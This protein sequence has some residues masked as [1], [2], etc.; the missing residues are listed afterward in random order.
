MNILVSIF[1]L[2]AYLHSSFFYKRKVAS[3]LG[4][5]LKEIN[6]IYKEVS[7]S[8]W[9][10]EIAQKKNIKQGLFDFSMLSPLRAQTL[11]VLCRIAK[12]EIVVETGVSEGFSSTF[13]LQALEKNNKG[14]LYS[15]D[16]PNQPGQK[17]PENKT[18][19]WLIPEDLKK[20]WMLI[21]GSSREKLSALLNDLKNIDIFFHDSD[22]SYENMMFEFE[23]AKSYLK[24]GGF[25]L[26]D[27]ITDNNSFRDFCNFNKCNYVRLF[28]LGII[29]KISIL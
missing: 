18:T 16:L 17:L 25:L 15:I 26:S 8:Q 27:D 20:R 9:F 29:K 6:L 19:G 21:L 14:H 24:S 7:S 4:H 12:P 2:S 5:S 1:R 28:K 13:I 10:K 23:S 11:Y 3:I 22:H